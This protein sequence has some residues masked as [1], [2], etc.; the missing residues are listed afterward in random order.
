MT[1]TIYSKDNCVQ[2]QMAKKFLTKEGVSFTEVN[3]DKESD[4]I[5]EVKALGFSSLPVITTK[6]D[7]FSG[8]QPAK[9]KALVA[10]N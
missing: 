7:S 5:D 10:K 4:R 6:D 9:L 8:F 1:I 3:L 2:C